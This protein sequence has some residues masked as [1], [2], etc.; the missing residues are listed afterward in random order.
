[1]IKD[2]L[3]C[4][5]EVRKSSIHQYGVFA[6]EDIKADEIIEEC[7]VPTQCIE[8]KYEYLDGVVYISNIDIMSQYRFT[9]PTDQHYWIL[10][11]G[12]A[13]MYNHSTNDNCTSY[14]DI[15]NRLLVFKATKDIKKDEE[16]VWNYGPNYKYNRINKKG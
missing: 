7:V 2:K 11:A 15:E 9:G 3:V 1:M 6:K 16:L 13:M 4:R 14:N 12:N 10:P 5:V 8:P